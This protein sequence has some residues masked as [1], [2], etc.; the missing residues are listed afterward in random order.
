MGFGLVPT[1][2]NIRKSFVP[3][4]SGRKYFS[5]LN[6]NSKKLV[7][8][9]FNLLKKENNYRESFEDRLRIRF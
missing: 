5:D 4:I 2:E 1:M 7:W 3:Y 6:S 8:R 9:E